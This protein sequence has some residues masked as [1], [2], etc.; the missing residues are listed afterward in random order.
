[1]TVSQLQKVA[2]GP[3]LA[4]PGYPDRVGAEERQLAAGGVHLL[5]LVLLGKGAELGDVGLVSAGDQ[6]PC[7]NL[8]SDVRTLKPIILDVLD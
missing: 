7:P 2:A 1:M 5:H 4:P 6:P 3:V 8:E